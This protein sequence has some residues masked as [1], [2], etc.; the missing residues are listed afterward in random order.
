MPK[1]KKKIII[2]KFGGSIL[3]DVFQIPN[4]IK[5]VKQELDIGNFPIVV[6][7]AFFGSTN[8]L[9]L[10]CNKLKEEFKNT[11]SFILLESNINI[12]RQIDA[13]LSSL[14]TSTSALFALALEYSNIS[15]KSLQGWQLPI[16]TDSKY[17][18]AKVLKINTKII[19]NLIKNNIIPIVAGFQG[20][21]FNANVTTLGRGGS[22]ITAL[23]LGAALKASRVDIYK[24]VLGIMSADPKIVKNT[25]LIRKLDYATAYHM[26]FF[27]MKALNARSC[28]IAM[29]YDILVRILSV[30]V[31]ESK[32]K[33]HDNS[34]NINLVN[35]TLIMNEQQ[36][37]IKN[38]IINKYSNPNSIK[39]AK[40]NN[41]NISI[42]STQVLN[43]TQNSN[44][45]GLNINNNLNEIVKQ[46]LENHYDIIKISTNYIV[47]STVNNFENIK[48]YSFS[49]VKNLHY[50][51]I[52][53]FNLTNDAKLI[54]EIIN[55]TSLL[56]IEILDMN[57][58]G[59][60]ILILLQGNNIEQFVQKFHELFIEQKESI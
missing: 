5:Y 11:K 1:V 57:I 30:Y 24:D 32:N 7:S 14:E 15:A 42:E 26:S 52:I 31:N 35:E 4:L 40:N 37:N 44:I 45:I 12:K 29:K 25:N 53:G 22:D 10:L 18:N 38:N 47:I 3:S 34:D 39:K 21:D 59:I 48:N 54:E 43:I 41:L 28:Q 17:N 20:V 13:S 36:I 6:I 16:L 23:A 51:A 56:S 49:L 27:G 33:D 8:N 50:V 46:L 2:Q 9:L 55:I 19:K 60:K 58:T